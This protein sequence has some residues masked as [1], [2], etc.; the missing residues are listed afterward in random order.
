MPGGIT[1]EVPKEVRTY[2]MYINGEWVAS[3]SSKTFPVYDPSTE[4]VIAQVPDAA[5]TTSTALLRPPKL[6]LKRARG[7]RAQH[8]SVAASFSASPKKS[9][10][11]FPRLPNSNAAIPVSPSSR[12]NSTLPSRYLLRI[13]RWPRN[14]SCRLRQ[15]RSRQCD[16]ASL[17]EPGWRRWTN[18]SLELS[19][20]YGCVEACSSD[21]RRLHLRSEACR[22][23]STH[24]S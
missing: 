7:A 2:Q 13:L 23:N 8:R 9:A 10:P 24:R 1:T 17:K 22:A 14:Q 15:P 3:K 19:P 5:P 4:E 12:P 16:V 21:C 11:I 20:A 18:Y 6:H